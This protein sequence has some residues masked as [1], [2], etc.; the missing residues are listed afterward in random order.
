MLPFQLTSSAVSG[1]PAHIPD[2]DAP[3]RRAEPSPPGWVV[4]SV[5]DDR[6]TLGVGADQVT[7]PEPRVVGTLRQAR[8]S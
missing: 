6:I 3:A 2:P 5:A 1:T 7:K 4:A 8:A